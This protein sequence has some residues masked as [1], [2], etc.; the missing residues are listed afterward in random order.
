MDLEDL[1][2]L[3]TSK[4][5]FA[6]ISGSEGTLPSAI[7][8]SLFSTFQ[9][10]FRADSPGAPN[11]HADAVRM[12]DAAGNHNWVNGEAI[13]L[14]NHERNGSWKLVRRRDV[15]KGRHIHKMVWVYKIKRNGEK[16]RSVCASKAG[17]RLYS[18]VRR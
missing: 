10:A 9:S 6:L 3:L 16:L 11:T 13:E 17:P 14:G 4:Q 15:S 12:D 8:H 2:D 5:I 7:H 1:G 18:R